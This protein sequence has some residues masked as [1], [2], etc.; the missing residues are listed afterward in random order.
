MPEN[1]F[2]AFLSASLQRKLMLALLAVT[3]AVMA[4]GGIYLLDSQQQSALDQL[5]A[6]ASS[7]TVMLSKNLAKPLWDMEL[8]TIQKN[9]DMVMSDPEIYSVALYEGDQ[10]QPMASR[11]RDGQ[12]VEGVERSAPVIHEREHPLPP[13]S[14]GKVQIVHTSKYMYQTLRQTRMMIMAGFLALLLSLSAATYILLNRMVQK[15]VGELLD[16]VQRITGG[17]LEVKIPVK[18]NDEIGLL[19]ENFNLMAVELKQ[20]MGALSTSEQNYRNINVTLESRILERTEELRLLLHFAGEGIFG[21][22]TAGQLTFI[23]PAALNMLGFTEDEIKGREVH[24]LILHSHKDGSPYPVEDSPIFAS[25]TNGAENRVTNEVLWHKDGL[26]FPVELSSTPVTK[27]GKVIGAVVIFH[28]ITKRLQLEADLNRSEKHYREVVNNVTECILVVQEGRIVF[29][30]PR[31]FELTGY[32]QD[33]LFSQSFV[34]AVHPDDR[35]IVIDNYMRRLRG[36]DV[37]QY[38]QFRVLHAQ[39]GKDIWLE[40]S[41]VMIEWEGKPATLSFATNITERRKLQES[42]NESMEESKRLQTIQ[43]E[44]ELQ[45]VLAARRHAEEATHAKSMFLA[46]MSHEIRTPLNAILGFSQLMQRDKA[47]SMESLE[48]LDIINRSGEHL[49]ALINDILEISKIEAGRSNYV[50]VTFDLHSFIHDIE[51]M[52]RLRTDA[53][54]LRFVLE[55]VGDIPRWVVTDEGKLRQILINLLGNA[56]KFTAD[57]GIVLRL[58][59]TVE[60]AGTVNLQFEVEDTGPGM[61]EEEVGRLFQA[62]EQ[63][64]SG[65]KT[66][67]TGLGLALCHGFVQIMNG[68]ISVNS[69]VNKGSIFRF[70][71]PVVEDSEEH[72]V[73][74]EISR[75]VLRLKPGQDEIKILIV[76][77]R[78]TNRQLLSQLLAAVGFTTLDA[79][80]GE[81]AVSR[82][83][84]WQPQVVLMDM[85]MPVMDGYEAT[86]HIKGNT[87]TRNTTIIAITASAFEEDKQRIF[88]VGADAYLA[89]P[90]KDSELFENIARLTG[91]EYLYEENEIAEGTSETSDGKALLMR[92]AVSTLFPDQVNRIRTAI[93]SADLDLLNELA[94]ELS[95]EQPV[96]AGRMQEMA[97]RYEYDALLELFTGKEMV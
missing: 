70:N 8:E 94:G 51:R 76:D 6:R 28:N 75:R 31:L 73:H 66:G 46:N 72:V 52:F 71:I 18:F 40:L 45:E 55:K 3:T 25:Y 29:A 58:K 36:E 83:Y 30:N 47:L 33:E 88:A 37:E 90:F 16:M 74:K 38:Y 44:R 17:D 54:N 78:E 39:T 81:E 15:P 62:F 96:L 42:L 13:V 10:K 79:D 60:Q 24:D 34:A 93:E 97:A 19:S 11:K 1:G 77:D 86:R 49:L 91:A 61:S 63:T 35:H 92:N 84:E 12:A 9:L 64:S 27:N 69:T 67:G 80:N 20:T 26:S 65:K 87:E 21:L 82:T 7:M 43:F 68:S 14:L 32:S 50:P 85:A 48:H 23:N 53:R 57:G 22:D 4:L 41:A 59:G 56:V 5:E 89:K 95:A 2:I